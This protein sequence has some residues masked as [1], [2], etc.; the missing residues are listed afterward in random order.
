M[1][2]FN[3]I[4]KNFYY[5]LIIP[6]STE[7]LY[8]IYIHTW[9]NNYTGDKTLNHDKNFINMEITK[10]YINNIFND[11]NMITKKIIIEN[12]I[13][14]KNKLNVN[15]YL[16][17]NTKERSIHN[18]FDNNYVKDMTNKLFFQFY[19]HYKLLQCLDLNCK[20]DFIIKT[21]PDMFYEKFDI[22]LFNYNVFFPNSHQSN[23]CNINQL[24]FGG[25][26][27]NMIN[28]LKFFE[29][30]IFYGNN[31]NFS[32]I[33]KYHKSDINFNNLFRYYIITYLNYN[34]FFTNY[35]PKIYRNKN[36]IITIT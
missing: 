16:D 4:I 28:I 15:E 36:H 33:N 20:Y 35:N 1:R 24:F 31:M 29:D 26:T 12:Q 5:N 32:L 23:G 27:E 11:N 14:I 13:Q 3:E 7:F 19:G 25:K 22:T 21:R 9:D 18:K 8:D 17:N 30:I 34:P 10:E 6:I 2:N